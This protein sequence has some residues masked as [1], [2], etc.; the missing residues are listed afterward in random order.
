MRVGGLLA[1]ITLVSH[2]CMRLKA[3]EKFCQRGTRKLPLEGARLSVSKF[4]VEAQTRFDCFKTGKVVR[5]EHLAL[6]DREVDCHL[7]EPTGMDRGMHHNQIGVGFGQPGDSCLAPMRRTVIDHPK[8]ARCRAVG[9]LLHHLCDQ[10]AARLAACR[11]FTSAPDN[12]STDVPSRPGLARTTTLV[13]ML[14]THRTSGRWGQAGMTP[15]AGLDTGLFI[16]T[17]AVILRAKRFS[18]PGPR[19]QIQ[20]SPSF[21]GKVWISRKNPVLVLPGFD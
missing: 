6:H 14:D 4:F 20:H 3:L 13:L 10:T 11:R 2:H 21:F 12:A 18:L 16:G 17:A 7:I 8:D 19:V 15:D 9:C 1:C 5:R